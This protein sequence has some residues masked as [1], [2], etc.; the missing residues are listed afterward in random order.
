MV[1][2]RGGRATVA[3]VTV[4]IDSAHHVNGPG[5]DSRDKLAGVTAA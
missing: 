3:A 1:I 5:R 4:A 2:A